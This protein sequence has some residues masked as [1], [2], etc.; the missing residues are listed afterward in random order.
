M[1]RIYTGCSC[2]DACFFLT[3][4]KQVDSS[5]R[6]AEADGVK[7]PT[8]L[9]EYCHQHKKPPTS[10]SSYD[11]TDDLYD[12]DDYYEDSSDNEEMVDSSSDCEREDLGAEDS[13]MA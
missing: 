13:G 4:R 12:G 8:T 11:I 3:F 1:R 7:V 9:A 2:N 10:T 6:E 5:R